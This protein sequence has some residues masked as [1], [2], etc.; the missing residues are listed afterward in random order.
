MCQEPVPALSISTSSAMPSSLNDLPH[1]AFGGGGAA[2]VAEA[3][4]EELG[5]HGRDSRELWVCS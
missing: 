4:E 1:H 5:G 2:D 3:D